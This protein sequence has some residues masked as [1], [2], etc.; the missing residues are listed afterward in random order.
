LGNN[1]QEEARVLADFARLVASQLD[2]RI[3]LRRLRLR[4]STPAGAGS[5]S[6]RID[7]RGVSFWADGARTC[8][9]RCEPR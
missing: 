1:A 9:P 4:L 7:V 3:A 8:G 2:L 6:P 5:L